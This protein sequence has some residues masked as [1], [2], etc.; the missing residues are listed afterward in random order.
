MVLSAKMAEQ[1]NGNAVKIVFNPL[2]MKQNRR[3]LATI[4]IVVV[5]T[6]LAASCCN[7]KKAAHANTAAVPEETPLLT[8]IDDYFIKEIVNL[9]LVITAEAALEILVVY[10]HWCKQVHYPLSYS[11]SEVTFQSQGR[12]ALLGGATDFGHFQP[13]P[14]PHGEHIP[15]L[16]SLCSVLHGLPVELQL[17]SCNV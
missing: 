13:S 8:A 1:E 17:V 16:D 15:L 9:I 5:A 2:I 4:V 3:I 14:A 6:L 12:A 10:V 7:R 11:V